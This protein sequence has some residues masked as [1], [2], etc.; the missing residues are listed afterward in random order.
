VKNHQNHTNIIENKASD[1]AKKRVKIF[2]PIQEED[3][4]SSSV[5]KEAYTNICK[6]CHSDLKEIKIGENLKILE[7]NNCKNLEKLL[8]NSKKLVSLFICGTNIINIK[9]DNFKNLEDLSLINFDN[10][11]IENNQ[12]LNYCLLKKINNLKFINNGSVENIYL[13]NIKN[14]ITEENNLSNF[15]KIWSVE[16]FKNL[17]HLIITNC[18]NLGSIRNNKNLESCLIYNCRS[19]TYVEEN[20]NQINRSNNCHWLFRD[21][22]NKDLKLNKLIKLQRNFKK[23]LYRKKIELNK[24]VKKYFNTDLT[25]IILDLIY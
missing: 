9:I 3:Q 15:Y 16:N 23:Y 4:S 17:M 13:I 20:K 21:D 12:K 14:L 19:L 24:E 2:F 1:Q 11:T 10:V 8:L 6:Q 5:E 25:L 7:I 18:N 22:I